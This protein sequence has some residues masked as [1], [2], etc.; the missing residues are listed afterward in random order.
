MAS[1]E[2]N[3]MKIAVLGTGMVGKTIATRLIHLGHH[4]GLGARS[5]TNEA[6]ATWA[7][8]G[9]EGASAGTF[10]D[11]AAEAEMVFLAVKGDVAE[12]VLKSA[13]DGIAGKVV[14]DI[15]NPL[16][17]SKGMPPTLFVGNDDS[18]GETLQRAFPTAKIVKTLNIVNADVM[19]NP[20][21]VPG[22]S[23]MLMCG[24]DDGAKQAVGEVLA[25]FG[26]TDVI[27]LGG[28]AQ[29]RAT[30]AY[31]PL[32]LRLWGALKTPNFNIKVVR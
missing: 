23:S 7:A 10:H 5:A 30:E 20:S 2:D 26:W 28:I 13:G 12:A 18:L 24:D 29:A 15:T 1:T 16:D 22:E 11:V 4:V 21:L 31:L 9:G 17:F 8:K 32:W 27:D 14:V 25:A 19:V 3:L 6:A